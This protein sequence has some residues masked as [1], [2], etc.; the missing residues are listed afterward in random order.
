VVCGSKIITIRILAILGLGSSLR[1]YWSLLKSGPTSPVVA[2][3]RPKYAAGQ[4]SRKIVQ[5]CGNSVFPQFLSSESYKEMFEILETKLL[6]KIYIGWS[7]QSRI[8]SEVQS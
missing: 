1:T 3:T 5:Q 2:P 4:G 6:I 8:I 7:H